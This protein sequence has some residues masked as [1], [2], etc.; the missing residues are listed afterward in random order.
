MSTNYIIREAKDADWQ[1]ILDI[2]RYYW[3]KQFENTPKDYE[4]ILSHLK[5][6]F[7]IRQ[8]YFNFWVVDNGEGEIY[9][10]QSCLQVF[11]SP[12]R[13]GY[14]GEISTYIRHDKQNGILAVRLGNFVVRDTLP[15]SPLMVLWTF[16]DSQNAP[17]QKLASAYGF[18][19][20]IDALSNSEYYECDELWILTFDK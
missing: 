7:D 16:I 3:D 9:G 12:L 18:K 8:G 1:Q 5:E 11:H 4:K 20:V 2:Y 13:K 10:W 14:N 17:S 15:K 6:A 19:K